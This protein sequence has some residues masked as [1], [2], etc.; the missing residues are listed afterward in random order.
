MNHQYIGCPT[1]VK[2]QYQ[3]LH[4]I[5]VFTCAI[6]VHFCFRFLSFIEPL[7]WYPWLGA[8]LVLQETLNRESVR[9]WGREFDQFKNWNNG[10]ILHRIHLISK[11][12]NVWTRNKRFFTWG[13]ELTIENRGIWFG[14][15]SYHNSWVFF[16]TSTN[17]YI[18]A[19]T[20]YTILLI[21]RTFAHVLMPS[22]GY[23][24]YAH[25]YNNLLILNLQMNSSL[26]CLLN[27]PQ[28]L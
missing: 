28:I 11:R 5:C 2:Y 25:L 19:T 17:Q 10:I 23:H 20:A 22:D 16:A 27:L 9:V 7:F 14:A 12:E 18:C 3:Y 8:I 26:Q 15:I 4:F 6:F 1:Q 13:Y 24:L 21:L